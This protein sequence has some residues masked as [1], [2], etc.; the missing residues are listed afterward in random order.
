MLTAVGAY[1]AIFFCCAN[2]VVALWRLIEAGVPMLI[3]IIWLCSQSANDP[4]LDA[5][6]E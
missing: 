3:G 1:A 6:K 2:P 5:A 4:K